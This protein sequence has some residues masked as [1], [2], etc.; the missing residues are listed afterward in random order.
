M[1]ILIVTDNGLE[2]VGGEQES[3]KIIIKGIHKHFKVGVIQPGPIKAKLPGVEYFDLTSKTRIKHLIKDPIDFIIYILKVRNIINTQKPKVI[4]TQAQVSFFIVALLKKL[5]LISYREFKFIH[6]ER[7]LYINYSKFFKSIFLFFM[8]ELDTLVTTTNYNMKLWKKI[9]IQKD[10]SLN[11]KV[12]EN[13]AGP[14][15]EKFNKE[16]EKKVSNNLV[17]G[18]AGRYSA[19]KNWPLAIEII[20]KLNEKLKDQLYIKMA[21]GC[22]DEK[23]HRYTNEMFDK[24]KQLLGS[25]FSG[26]ININLEEMD[27]FYYEI[28]IF[29]LTSKKHSES[30]GRTLVEA[31]S[32]KTVVLTTDAGGPVEIV[33]KKENVLDTS[34]EFVNKILYLHENRKEMEG[35]KKNN[36]I[37]VRKKY[38]LRNNISKHLEMYTTALNKNKI[39]SKF[40]TST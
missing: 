30:F 3:T 23:S 26:N 20:E 2:T 11:F 33:E 29:I 28:D 13:T 14:L 17:V 16:M 1:D 6:T 12:I 8:N 10:I 25:R 34:E 4:H 19:Q 40:L 32:R 9:L 7:G 31:M 27:K 39:I 5:K 21:V 38:S 15:F 24:L 37:L 35:E 36:L 18:F 22:L